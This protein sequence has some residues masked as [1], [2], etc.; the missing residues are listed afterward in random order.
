M[1]GGDLLQQPSTPKSSPG[2][3]P[4][5][6]ESVGSS[7]PSST[8]ICHNDSLSPQTTPVTPESSFRYARQLF[9]SKPSSA[10]H[11]VS[12]P[13]VQLPLELRRI[14]NSISERGCLDSDRFIEPALRIHIQKHLNQLITDAGK[15]KRNAFNKLYL[16]FGKISKL[17][18]LTLSFYD[19]AFY[20]YFRALID[21]QIP[22]EPTVFESALM[23]RL[24]ENTRNIELE[25]VHVLDACLADS[26]GTRILNPQN[27]DFETLQDLI[28]MMRGTLGVNQSLFKIT[29]GF[30]TECP[31]LSRGDLAYVLQK[32][33]GL[34]F[35]KSLN[36]D[37]HF[38]RFIVLYSVLEKLVQREPRKLAPSI[39]FKMNQRDL[40]ATETFAEST[41]ALISNATHNIE[42]LQVEA[43][44]E[45]YYLRDHL[46]NTE[47]EILYNMRDAL[48]GILYKVQP[49]RRDDAEEYKAKFNA[50]LDEYEGVSSEIKTPTAPPALMAKDILAPFRRLLGTALI[51]ARDKYLKT[52]HGIRTSYSCRDSTQISVPSPFF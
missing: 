16:T 25:G 18:F 44:Q 26:I 38:S 50:F 1:N 4:A 21:R 30:A 14:F 43:S 42:T 23:E 9:A 13:E 20:S 24:E 34:K 7:T 15:V 49:L 31:T 19:P 28:S 27:I 52:H 10:A 17:G 47:N 46:I 22:G 29:S 41:E 3:N 48:L 37:A 51:K 33:N 5:S 12:A 40:A 35:S 32:L 6:P 8:P 36:L 2:A 45:L 39:L 11:S